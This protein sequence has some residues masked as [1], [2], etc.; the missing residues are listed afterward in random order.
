M[1]LLFE[2]F[3]HSLNSDEL[4][5]RLKSLEDFMLQNK[6]HGNWEKWVEQ[7]SSLPQ[8]KPSSIHLNQNIIS[9]GNN[10]DLSPSQQKHLKQTL[11]L[12]LPWRKGPYQLFDIHIDAEWRSD[13]KWDRISQH[14]PSLKD[15]A[16]LDIGCGN[17]YHCWRVQEHKPLFTLGLDLTIIYFFQFLI[18]QNYIQQDNF[19]LFPFPLEEIINLKPWCDFAFSMGVLYHRK[20]PLEHLKQIHDLL[21][22]E[23][24]LLLETL[25]IEESSGTILQPKPRYARMRNVHH[26]PS[27]TTLEAWLKE[28]QYRNIQ[29][30][31]TCETTTKEQRSTPWMPGSSLKSFLDPHNPKLT[32]EGYP[33]PRRV[34]YLAQK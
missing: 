25:Y 1:N 31:H 20:N 18:F 6:M 28:C 12:F 10:D 23:G 7:I 9:V 22:K 11:E 24:Y 13:K 2:K 14:L 15:K 26:I 21:N 32:I 29:Q 30:I 17:G 16:I 33:A 3:Y 27:C 8:I 5:F 34:V 4:R 19:A